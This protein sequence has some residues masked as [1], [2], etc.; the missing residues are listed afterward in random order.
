M[1]SI[2]A[3]RVARKS[4]LESILEIEQQSFADEAFSATQFKYLQ[5]TPTSH[6]I[7][8]TMRSVIA[9]Y[10]VLLWRKNSK[11]LRVYSIAVDK[12]YWGLGVAHALLNG[13]KRFAKEKQLLR[14]TLEVKIGNARAISLYQKEGF[15]VIAQKKNYYDYGSHGL[16]MQ[17]IIE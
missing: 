11:M 13:A 3:I 10:A 1:S 15:C 2:P 12:E 17:Y 6:F 9:G 16:I 14:L 5:Q 7:V 4:D 8:A